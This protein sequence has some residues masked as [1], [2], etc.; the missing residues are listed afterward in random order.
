LCLSPFP[1]SVPSAFSNGGE[2]KRER[3]RE[4][5]K[6][7]ERDRKRERKRERKV[8]VLLV[9]LGAAGNEA[10]AHPVIVPAARHTRVRKHTHTSGNTH[11]Y[12]SH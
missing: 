7:R 11:T 9:W 5:A 4:R 10:Q 8:A 12:L 2:R 3:E 6:K 1:K